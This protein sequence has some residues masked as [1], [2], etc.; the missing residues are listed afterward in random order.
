MTTKLIDIAKSAAGV[1]KAAGANDARVLASRSREV[2]VEW[3][4][5]KLDRIQES[6]K[7]D[8]AITL[9]VDG[10]YSVN[11]TADLR[12]DALKKYITDA[13][14]MTRLL[15]VDEHRKLPDPKLYQ[16]EAPGDLQINDPSI[17]SVQADSRLA[18]AKQIEEAARAGDKEGAVIS[19][20]T[21]VS[22][23][24]TDLACVATNGFE[25][26]DTR[27][28][29][30]RVAQV[31]VKDEGSRKPVA[32]SYSAGRF[33]GDQSPAEKLGAE[34][35]ERALGLRKTKQ[36]ASGRYDLVIENRVVSRLAGQ[37]AA[38][39]NGRSLQQKQSFYEGKL[40]QQVASKLLT[41][42]SDPR[43][44]RGLGTQA[45]DDEGM[46]TIARPIFEKGVLKTFFLDT[47]YASKL[48][49]EPTSA[50]MG[51]IVWEPGKRDAAAMIKRLKKGIFV[52][53]F[54]GGNSNSTTGDFSMGIKGFLVKNGKI[55][56]PVSEMNIAGNHLEFW[57]QLVEVGS[58]V[59]QSSANRSPSIRFKKV[60]CSG[61]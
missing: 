1:A 39:L 31:S 60:Q 9:F 42:K 25:G 61:S 16:G 49:L 27:T 38:P 59:W 4:D 28:A 8:L 3:R 29:F 20:T 17:T 34:A 45:W 43:L 54:M 2:K 14:A 26:E 15:A 21:E 10:R 44:P 30:W 46:A 11:M 24:C 18:T 41:I 56:H 35:V 36:V 53:G 58:D 19:V 52:T 12:Q 40:G 47:Y 51:N 5:G 37:L 7:K 33:N 55:I 32:W 13:V 6:T 22:D 23:E 50:S 57:K 48:G